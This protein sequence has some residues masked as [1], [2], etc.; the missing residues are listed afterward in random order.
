M[1]RKKTYDFDIKEVKRKI[2]KT[3]KK[4]GL[5]ATQGDL[6]RQTALPNFQIKQGL[7]VVLKEYAGHMKLTESGEIL[8]YFPNGL[9]KREGSLARFKQGLGKV[10]QMVGKILAYL[11]K[12]W[13]VVMLIGY[14]IIF[15][16][17]AVL[18]L[19]ALMRGGGRDRDRGGGMGFNGNILYMLQNVIFYSSIS[20]RGLDMDMGRRRAPRGPRKPLH[21]SIFSYVFGIE[22]NKEDPAIQEKK[23]I[24]RYL[25]EN[26][27]VIFAEEVM[28]LTG[29][30]FDQS[31]GL[32]NDL[33]VE[34]E[35][36]PRVTEEGTI[37]F[38]FG[39]LLFSAQE[40]TVEDVHTGYRQLI[41]FNDNSKKF[42]MVI[43]FFNGFNLL[44]GAYFLHY[45]MVS[46]GQL[47]PDG[48]SYLYLFTVSLLL[49][50]MSGSAV[51]SVLAYGLGYVP[52]VF[53]VLF[54]LVPLLRR[55]WEQ[56]QN[57]QIQ[58]ENLRKKIY[59]EILEHPEGFDESRLKALADW[60]RPPEAEKY[61][62][63]IIDKFAAI[64][65]DFYADEDTDNARTRFVRVKQE[66][67]DIDRLRREI[68]PEDYELGDTVY[69]SQ[70]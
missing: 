10:A 39:Q 45:S 29:R 36:E 17:L 21:K 2:L 37:Y 33:L 35:G 51:Q 32:I 1:T 18:A 12:I 15:A 46:I 14:F 67:E 23:L 31:Q 53:S 26:K 9:H 43:S 68:K 54:F 25:K 40:D 48:L 34:Y 69:D 7:N 56:R 42:N 41:P 28:A 5:E 52:V 22:Q 30:D 44:F 61:R 65:G 24:L 62:R 63:R 20:G 50:G 6:V 64:K 19:I 60:E 47:N 27:G 59:Q 16:V 8:Y 58:R 70:V 38:Q 55:L 13:I 4:G 57:H 3:F 66:K 49:G 11:F